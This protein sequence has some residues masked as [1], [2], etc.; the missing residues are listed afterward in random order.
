MTLRGLRGKQDG[1]LWELRHGV[2]RNTLIG[3]P[4]RADHPCDISVTLGAQ[5]LSPPPFFLL[6]SLQHPG[7]GASALICKHLGD[8]QGA[9]VSASIFAFCDSIFVPCVCGKKTSPIVAAHL[10]AAC[11]HQRSVLCASVV[12]SRNKYKAEIVWFSC[13]PPGRGL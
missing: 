3:K 9:E 11:M 1:I 12:G 4:K 10:V 8:W 6:P 7:C 2:A 13:A 5:V